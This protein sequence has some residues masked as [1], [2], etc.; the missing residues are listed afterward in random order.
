[1]DTRKY[2]YCPNCGTQDITNDGVCFHCGDMA[3][4]NPW[5][6]VDERLPEKDQQVLAW[7]DNGS[8]QYMSTYTWDRFW[9]PAWNN[10]VY[11][12]PPPNP[13]KE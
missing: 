8:S 4:L 1:M 13:P 2:N 5:I 7:I 12:A 9:G 3:Y 11:W 6:S 10:V